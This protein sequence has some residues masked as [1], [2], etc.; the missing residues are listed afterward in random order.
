MMVLCLVFLFFSKYLLWEWEFFERLPWCGRFVFTFLPT[1]LP[2]TPG[3]CYR[4]VLITK[5][6]EEATW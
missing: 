5:Q 2:Q 6:W 1:H 3:P 4:G